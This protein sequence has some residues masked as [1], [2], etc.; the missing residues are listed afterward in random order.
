MSTKKEIIERC[1]MLE[2]EHEHAL[3]TILDLYKYMQ[4]S[5]FRTGDTLD[6][7]ININDVFARLRPAVSYLQ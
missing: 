4:S 5:K 2:Y 6:G 7:Y 1:L 3:G